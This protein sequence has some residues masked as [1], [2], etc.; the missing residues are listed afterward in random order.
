MTFFFRA[1]DGIAD[2]A[3]FGSMVSILMVLY[4]D[5]VSM[6]MASTESVFGAGYALGKAKNHK[7]Y[8]GN[9]LR[10]RLLIKCKL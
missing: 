6:I 2:A 8:T 4:P 3:A 7:N 5:K 10:M 9:F 1:L